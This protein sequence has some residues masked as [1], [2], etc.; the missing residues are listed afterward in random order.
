MPMVMKSIRNAGVWMGIGM[1]IGLAVDRVWLELQKPAARQFPWLRRQMNEHVNPWLLE[2][3]VPGSANAEIATLEHV[4]RQTG[5][6]HHTPVHPTLSG[7]TMLIPVPLGVG[8]QWARN[9]LHAGRARLQLHETLYD[10]D[11]P[12]LIAVAETGFYPPRVAA[13]FDRMGWRYLR[14]RVVGTTQGTFASHAHWLG[15]T[16]EAE[17]SLTEPFEIPVEPRMVTREP[18]TS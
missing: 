7:D 15:S 10:L 8:S 18:A 13:P 3:N 17:P 11:L 4:G 2:H 12:E 1:G 16:L 6:V 5:A 9:V 14:L